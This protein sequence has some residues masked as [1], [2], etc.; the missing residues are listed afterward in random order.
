MGVQLHNENKLNEM[1][2]I[3]IGL[4]KYVPVY[5]T[6]T[7][8]EVDGKKYT[9][10]AT[11]LSPCLLFGDQLTSARVRGTV[12]LRTFHKTSLDR[13]E[14]HIPVTSD[15]HARLCLVT[16]SLYAQSMISIYYVYLGFTK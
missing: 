8:I 11:V 16:V 13:L 5:E 3:L 14:G 2:Q 15:W 1:T 9:Q 7:S 12:A 10:P 6:E 4:N